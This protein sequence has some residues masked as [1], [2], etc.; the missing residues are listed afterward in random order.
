VG[1]WAIEAIPF[2]VRS[3]YLKLII[4]VNRIK[5]YFSGQLSDYLRS[6]RVEIKA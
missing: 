6:G 4:F 3:K 2:H 5:N 1:N